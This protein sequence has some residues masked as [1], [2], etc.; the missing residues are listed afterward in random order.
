MDKTRELST[1]KGIRLA[2]RNKS[3]I[4]KVLFSDYQ[5]PRDNRFA[6]R[7]E[8]LNEPWA[9]QQDN[10]FRISNL[11]YGSYTLHLK[12]QG[13]NGQWS[14]RELRLPLLVALPFYLRWWFL[15]ACFLLAAAFVWWRIHTLKR[16]AFKLEAEVKKRTHQIEQ[17]KL[18]IEKQAAE[19]RQLAEEI[20]DLDKLEAGRLELREEMAS[21]F[22][23]MRQLVS[24]FESHAQAN[25]IEL[26]FDYQ[27]EQSLHLRLDVNKF[28]RILY[29][30]LSNALK[31]TPRGGKVAVRD[32]T[33]I[34]YTE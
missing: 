10:T 2:A 16:A 4:L 22:P 21:F 8:G 34:S 20:L 5:N 30:L 6:F 31:F 11:P 13:A 28:E 32:C 18:L 1:A 15:A 26:Q 23:L 25:G 17:D 14:A 7:I 3:F 12:A 19:L 9:Y 24:T 27:A 29:N 33:I